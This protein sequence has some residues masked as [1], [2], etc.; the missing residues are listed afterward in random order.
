MC[1]LIRGERKGWV[2]DLIRGEEIEEEE[3]S[4]RSEEDGCRCEGRGREVGEEIRDEEVTEVIMEIGV[5]EEV[6][7]D[8]T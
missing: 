5:I 2:C 4:G 1:D 6:Y 3:H 7:E 8:I